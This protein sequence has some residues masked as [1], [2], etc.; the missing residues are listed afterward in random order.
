M[1]ML[2][3]SLKHHAKNSLKFFVNKHT[4]KPYKKKYHFIL[5]YK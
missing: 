5:E 4:Q 2:I 3:D 1:L